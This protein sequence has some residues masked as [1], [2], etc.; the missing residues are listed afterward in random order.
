MKTIRIVWTLIF[1]LTLGAL[2]AGRP[3]LAAGPPADL[4]ERPVSPEEVKAE[5]RAA[6]QAYKQYAWGH[7]ALQPLS[8]KPHDWYKTPLL[9]T[10][11]DGLDTMIV[12]GLTAEAKEAKELIFT[13]LSFDQDMEVQHFEVCIRLL[14]GL[15]S[16]YQWDGD[17]RF[18]ALAKDLA[19]RMLPVFDSKTGMPYRFVNLRTGKTRGRLS[20]PAEVGTYLIEYGALSKLT[21]NP[22]YYDKAKRAAVA[23][24]DRRSKIGLVGTVID[25]DTGVWVIP[26][27]H[28]GGGIDS[29][30]EYLLKSAILLDDADLRRMWEE[31]I[32]PI[33]RYLADESTGSLWYGHA[34]MR[35]GRRTL[36]QFGALHAFF[37]AL[38]AL[39]GDLDRAARLEDSCYRMWTLA[40]I[41]PEV[42][43]YQAMKVV[44]GT[45]ML[46][47]EIVESAYYLYHY[48]G[49]E[50]Y[51]RM[52]YV[53]WHDTIKYCK[54]DAGFA[55][56]A[57]VRT[58]TKA[59]SMESYFFAETLKYYYLL[60]SPPAAFPFEA[61][62]FNTEAHPIKKTW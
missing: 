28:V 50:K 45:Y 43:D 62:I 22:V 33:N 42:L 58:K 27:A 37:P 7:D 1:C 54:T 16:A 41:E 12:M 10:P 44:V 51:R 17:P 19:D 8:K 55:A 2:V 47:P 36:T 46:R 21:G 13:R 15:I 38:L 40:G 60:F 26:D 49:D 11:V 52:G 24:H 39:G 56:L 31:S 57:D 3:A 25:V 59:D 4:D 20:G 34:D 29:F 9:M 23:L 18:L 32:G 14:G 53:F 48:T 5:F 30:Y 61:V 6:W 35:T